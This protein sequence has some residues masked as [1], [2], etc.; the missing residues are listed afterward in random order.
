MGRFQS[1]DVLG[2]PLYYAGS[3]GD[4]LFGIQEPRVR[5]DLSKSGR[6]HD[7]G[8][9]DSITYM[10]SASASELV[11]PQPYSE[12]WVITLPNSYYGS[13]LS[14]LVED[15][16]GQVSRTGTYDCVY[17][18]PRAGAASSRRGRVSGSGTFKS[19]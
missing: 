18:E 12:A 5:P 11:T 16:H 7:A 9:L 19:D 1:R 14:P 17:H 2:G 6:I 4:F 13:Q 8:D 10:R 15:N 3:T